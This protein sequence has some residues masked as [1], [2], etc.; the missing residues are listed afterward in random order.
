MF[1]CAIKL[2]IPFNFVFKSFWKNKAAI[3][4]T[5]VVVALIILGAA[6]GVTSFYYKKRNARLHTRLHDQLFD[7]YL[8]SERTRNSS[9][10]P[11]IGAAPIDPREIHHDPTRVEEEQPRE[12][13]FYVSPTSLNSGESTKVV[14]R[15]LRSY[16]GR[17]SYPTS[18]DS[19][20]GASPSS[21]RQEAFGH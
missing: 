11:S 3:A 5:F 10:G 19:F 16:I 12:M 1:S 13:S 20:Y 17:E 4:G 6:A 18:I 9:P 7:K 8:K 21:G 14:P 2:T 15:T